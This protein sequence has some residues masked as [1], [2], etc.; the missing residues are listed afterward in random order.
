MS[1]WPKISK[2]D[3]GISFFYVKGILLLDFKLAKQT[4][5]VF[6]YK[7]L[8]QLVKKNYELLHHSP[9][10]SPVFKRFGSVPV[11]SSNLKEIMCGQYFSSNDISYRSCRSTLQTF[12]KIIIE[13]NIIIINYRNVGINVLTF[14]RTHWT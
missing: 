4:T 7:L 9:D 8:N 3:E 5:T 2:E 11:L 10:I 13:L 14:G 6:Y 12:R 1:S